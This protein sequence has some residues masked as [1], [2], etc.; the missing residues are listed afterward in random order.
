MPTMKKCLG[1]GK[2]VR[3]GHNC[4]KLREYYNKKIDDNILEIKRLYE[5]EEYS[6]MEIC[7]I[8][9]IPRRKL[10]IRL[11]DE[12]IYLRGL[13]E[14]TKRSKNLSKQNCIKKYGVDNP[15]KLDSI[16]NKV[17]ETNKK[18]LSKNKDRNR[19]DFIQWINGKT[20]RPKDKKRFAKFKTEVWRETKK[21]K[22]MLKESDRCYYTKHKIFHNDGLN[23]YNNDYH[24]SIDHRISILSAFYDNWSVEKTSNIENLCWASRLCNSL[25]RE[26][27]SYEFFKSDILKRLI[28]YENQKSNPS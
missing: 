9:N 7:N 26:M 25:K 17:R 2:I 22:K 20:A 6:L 11:K 28:E 16:K 19:Y 12:G 23:D 13:Q 18:R 10:E 1:C 15:S 14:K 5:E 4:L 8:L 21:N 24:A 3:L 27:T